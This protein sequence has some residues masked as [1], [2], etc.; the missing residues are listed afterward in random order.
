MTSGLRRAIRV[1]IVDDHP[2]MREGIS[3]LIARE[4][5]MSVVAEASSGEEAIALYPRHQPDITMMDLRLPDISG[6]E[7]LIAI[8]RKYPGAR[9]VIFTTFEGDVEMERALRAGARGY[10]LKTMPAQ[11]LIPAIREVHAGRKRISPAVAA[12]I[13]QY[14]GD[15]LLTQREIDVLLQIAA[16]NRNRD[17]ADHLVISEWT[18]K[19]HVKHVIEKLGARDRAE[20]VSI[21]MRR[22]VISEQ[23]LESARNLPAR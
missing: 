6:I 18:V 9:I 14:M 19:V 21:A 2:L 20:A 4:S 7:A 1:M 10:M 8:R 12:R 3:A 5:D 22:G 13:A 11:D 23:A 17:I 15:E 16:G